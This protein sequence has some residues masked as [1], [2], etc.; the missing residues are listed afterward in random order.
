M[1]SFRP[2]DEEPP[3]PEGGG[4]NP[5]VDFHGERRRNETHQSTTWY[6]AAE[7]IP[8]EDQ[9][10]QPVEVAQLWR[11]LSGQA[12]TGRVQRDHPAVGVGGNPLPLADVRGTEPILAVLPVGAAGG[13]VKRDQGPPVH[14]GRVGCRRRR[15]RIHPRRG[16]L[17][18]RRDGG[19]DRHGIGDLGGW[20]SGSLVGF[21]RGSLLRRSGA[22]R[23]CGCLRGRRTSRA[24]ELGHEGQEELSEKYLR[25]GRHQS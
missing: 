21:R 4:R 14:F 7:L 16:S 22:N 12:I 25:H 8:L 17:C 1:K 23:R 3:P 5:E 9:I 24:G 19:P 13:L 6:A 11:Q 15:C 10:Q 18:W 20:D 2:R